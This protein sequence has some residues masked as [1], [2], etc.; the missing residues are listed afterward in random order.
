MSKLVGFIFVVVSGLVFVG[1]GG[2]K[3][4][5]LTTVVSKSF[6]VQKDMNKTQTKAILQ[7]EPDNKQRIDNASGNYEIWKYE[8][9]VVSNEDTKETTYHNVMIVFKNDKVNSVG[10]F[11][12]KAPKLMDK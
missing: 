2:D 11:S 12:C 8:G 4:P 5:I 3:Q 7:F 9:R 10:T 1:C 6:D